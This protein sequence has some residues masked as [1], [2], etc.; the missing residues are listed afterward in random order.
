[1]EK[2]LDV[3]KLWFSDG[4]IFVETAEGKRYFQSLLRYPRL[5]NAT[6]KERGNFNYS[7]SGIH[8]PDIDED[9]SFESFLRENR[10]PSGISR[11]FLTH[12]ELNASAVARRLNIPQ[13]VLAAYIRGIKKPSQRREKDIINEIKTIGKELELVRT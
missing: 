5:M 8:F 1:M 6:D 13:S 3:I 10:E 12:P 2:E 9:I 11:I 7:W 4:K